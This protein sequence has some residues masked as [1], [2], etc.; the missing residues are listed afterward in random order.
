MGLA[1]K[2][3]DG[4]STVE[5]CRIYGKGEKNSNIIFLFQT[6]FERFFIDF[7]EFCYEIYSFIDENFVFYCRKLQKM[8]GADYSAVKGGGLKLKAGKKNL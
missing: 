3:R 6:F 7:F 5:S 8:P 2:L 1:A 4:E